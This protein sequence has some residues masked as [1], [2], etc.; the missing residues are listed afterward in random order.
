[1]YKSQKGG[2]WLEVGG[3]RRLAPLALSHHMYES[4]TA[5]LLTSGSGAASAVH[6]TWPPAGH[7]RTPGPKEGAV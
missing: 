6:L 1:M 5:A 7:N 4:D 3:R 2:W